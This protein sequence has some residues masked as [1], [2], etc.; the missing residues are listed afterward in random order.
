[1]PRRNSLRGL[2]SKISGLFRRGKREEEEPV[3]VALPV[4]EE[5]E[6]KLTI[7]DRIDTIAYSWF[8]ELGAKLA[9]FFNLD[10]ALAMAGIET[11]PTIY[12]T[13]MLFF[14]VVAACISYFYMVLGLYYASSLAMQLF[15]ILSAIIMPVAV[16][17]GFLAYPSIKASTRASA[18]EHELPFM[19]AYLT[20]VAKG[21][22]TIVRAFERLANIEILP[23][24]VRE[25]R[26]ILR[27]I[28]L[29]G[30][31]PLTAME[32]NAMNHPNRRYR[33]FILGYTSTV[34]SGGDIIHYLTSK[35]EGLFEARAAV[36]KS[37]ADRIAMLTE[38]YV[39]IA[40]IM[41]LGF[42]IF[43]SVSSITP[44]G[45]PASLT[46]FLLFAYVFL[47]MFSLFMLLAISALQPKT[48]LPMPEPYKALVFSIPAGI[49]VAALGLYLTGSWKALIGAEEPTKETISGVLMSITL[50][51][52]ILSGPPAVYY[53]I[54][55][56]T[57]KGVEE[58][59]ASFLRDMVEV[60]KTGLS[61]E[62]CII[63]VAER[64]YGRLTPAIRDLAKLLSWG[65]PFTRAVRTIVNRVR[66]WFARVA[67]T[68]L[69]DAVDVGGG[70][71]ETLE[72]LARFTFAL[73]EFE[74]ELA[75]KLKPY[76]IMPYF[77]AIMNAVATIMVIGFTSETF[78]VSPSALPIS[79]ETIV[80]YFTLSM[81]LNS[82]IMGLVAG[83]ISG[84]HLAAG[85]THAII[86]TVI[87]Y[88]AI[89]ILI[90]KFIAFA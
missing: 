81:L 48:S 25:A 56:Y 15:V 36:V 43:F 59:V 52:I 75:S 2:A 86:L 84:K 8:G 30:K 26:R 7:M 58:Y 64:D 33:D 4:E 13:R 10:E 57:S 68:F 1:M 54:V 39:I 49:L 19:A 90:M 50:G 51:L 87:V 32:E 3:A 11:Y 22:V 29:F 62:R 9:K 20:T 89:V 72:A 82:W 67:L 14:T 24:A 23:A 46:N 85:F 55:A 16:F 53:S 12:A 18:M 88:A 42:Y 17:T 63:H 73:S 76:V 35:T 31:D 28:R 69:V 80:L 40:V 83:R 45:K 37:I 78:K 27:D 66:N 79:M 65:F 44:G 60:R 71:V 6:G 77:G 70:S 41:G 61:P 34:R 5:E 74:K 47:P 38:A 21:R